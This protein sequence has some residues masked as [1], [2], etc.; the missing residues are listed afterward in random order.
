MRYAVAGG[1]DLHL[2]RPAVVAIAHL[3][4]LQTLPADRSKRTQIRVS[5]A[6]E[7]EER[8][9]RDRIPNSL[10]RA[11]GASLGAARRSRIG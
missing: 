6:I 1:F 2:D 4:M 3:Q 5:G 7:Q 11:Q 8:S 9:T 10:L